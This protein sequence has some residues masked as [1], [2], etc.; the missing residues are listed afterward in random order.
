MDNAQQGCTFSSPVALPAATTFSWS[1]VLGSGASRALYVG[2]STS[3]ESVTIGPTPPRVSVTYRN[4]PMDAIGSRVSG[5]G[6]L[7][8]SRAAVEMFRLTEAQLAAATGPDTVVVTILQPVNYA[9]GGSVS[10]SGVNQTTPNRTFVSNSGDTSVTPT[11][12]PSVS[13]T[14]ASNEMVLDT[15]AQPFTAGALAVGPGQTER[16]NGISCFAGLSSIGA[17]STEPGG[18][19]TT[20]MSWTQGN[21]GPWAIGA[22][23]IVPLAPTQV[24]LAA[25]EAMRTSA[26]VRL[27][28]QTGY[29]VNNLGFNLYREVNGNRV[30]VTP[31]MVA[32]SALMAGQGVA[33]TAGRSYAWTDKQGTA[34]AKYWLESIDLDGR[35]ALHGPI[36]P[37]AGDAARSMPEQ[38]QS[39]LLDQ[40]N[41][42]TTGGSTTAAQK[43]YAARAE[44]LG[45]TGKSKSPELSLSGQAS[46][47]SA[48]ALGSTPQERQRAL[49]AQDAV[50]L[51]VNHNGWYRVGQQELVAAGLNPNA[52]PRLLQLY[53]NGDE[54]PMMV[55]SSSGNGFGPGDSIEFYGIG[56]NTPWTDTQAYWLING[57]T[58]GERI[59]KSKVR[60]LRRPTASRPNQP[61]EPVK[62]AEQ[63]PTNQQPNQPA[64]TTSAQQG[65]AFNWLPALV[66]PSLTPEPAGRSTTAQ[67]TTRAEITVEKPVAQVVVGEASM[68]APAT[69]T[70]SAAPDTSAARPNVTSAPTLAA[71]SAPQPANSAQPTTAF[72]KPAI[73]GSVRRKRLRRGA[74]AA[75]RNSRAAKRSMNAASR[76]KLKSHA[77]GGGGTVV[78]AESFDYT[79]ERADRTLYFAALQNGDEDN[80][81]GQ[82]IGA[83]SATL[84]LKTHHLASATGQSKLEVVLQGV[85][86]GTHLVNVNLNGVFLGQISFAG[87]AHPITQFQVSNALLHEG[88]NTLVLT[89]P[90]G[91]TDLSLVDHVG[92][93]YPHTYEADNNSLS[94]SIGGSQGVILDGFNSSSI[95]MLDIS[96]PNA[97]EELVAQSGAEG[98]GYG[99]A[100]EATR[101]G[102]LLAMTDN[103]IEHPAQVTR[104]TPSHW[105]THETGADLLI[106]THRDFMGSLAPLVTLRQS[107]GLT[108][109]VID[110]EDIYDEFSYGT[111]STP[112]LRDFF[113]WASGNWQ[114][115]P[116]YVLL[117]GDC[118]LDPH[119][120][121]GQGKPDYVPTK[122]VDTSYLETASDDSLA[123]FNNDGVP[124]MAVGRL[125]VRTVA[126]ATTV[127][128]KIVSF[129]N[130]NLRRGALLVSDKK[131]EFDF[132]AANGEIRALLPAGMEVQTIN[133]GNND[134]NTVRSQIVSGI[135][136][137]PLLVNY[138]GHG[139]VE[140]WTG[141][142]ILR[143]SDA[144]QLTNN[145]SLS[146]F[147]MMTCL[148]GFAQDVYTESLGEALLRSGQGGAAAVWASSGLTEPHQ[149]ALINRQLIRALFGDQPKT[150]GD[151]II[152]AKAATQNMD[153]RRT[154]MLFG[155]PST[156]LR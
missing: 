145:G 64:P 139:S 101:G 8:D 53:A 21:T 137:G 16:W 152:S 129:Q 156:R 80:F 57:S 141:A 49:A 150:L 18:T 65:A 48:N 10:F 7:P 54:V 110:V 94:F 92:L 99:V 91:E 22:V 38:G 30:R 59:R 127:I 89:A 13:V 76:R 67:T 52:D 32:G 73:K 70:G 131:D 46:Q 40:L 135:N 134:A 153:T 36:Q 69:A 123:D 124:E 3:L 95:R 50:K 102:N 15:V 61:V 45:A 41:S 19:T 25:F 42:M 111:H 143:T 39:P 1:H 11:N 87:R 56:L 79:V 105:A 125:P 109:A 133:R 106:V 120:Y 138:A 132:E 71:T 62:P 5:E 17:G 103:M 9:V 34:D 6:A 28:W 96:D 85:T 104:N 100:F 27:R 144:A 107:Q 72:V 2:V 58:P 24:E 130:G 51:L 108:V 31:S 142:G 60:S 112:A 75:R 93:T 116:R 74:A 140:M 63:T 119:N 155:D 14:T 37:A 43:E 147:V 88:E 29:E 113:G 44:G 114:H 77:T 86:T 122:L 81:F 90:G 148:N 97:V 117:V 4:A 47:K 35:R 20:T 84:K 66:L 33:L 149:Q 126:E 68:P 151:A 82:L 146:L 55:N 98:S 136:Q 154:W 12:T 23:S 83:E 118:S 115:A 26:G 78:V 121:L 128:G